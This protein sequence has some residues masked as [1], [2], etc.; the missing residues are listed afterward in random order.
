MTPENRRLVDRVISEDYLEGL[1]DRSM[2]DLRTLREEARECENEMSF[3][4]RLAQGRIDILKAELARRE[5][6]DSEDLLSLLPRIL[7][8]RR[9]TGA[10]PLPDRAPDFSVPRSAHVD[11]KRAEEIEGERILATLPDLDDS[12]IDEKLGALKQHEQNLS[13]KRK[14]VHGVLDVLQAEIVRRYQSGEADP[15]SALS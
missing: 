15:T 4:R 2:E 12:E 10:N 13:L 6:K 1:G 14:R 8:D 3:E 7:A 5:G 9:P 11:R